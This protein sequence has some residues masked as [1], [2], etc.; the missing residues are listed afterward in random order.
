MRKK[1]TQQTAQILE[2]LWLVSKFSDDY[3]ERRVLARM[4]WHTEISSASYLDF[5]LMAAGFGSELQ[6]LD[7]DDYFKNGNVWFH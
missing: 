4:L 7:D 3:G 1:N 6:A 2:Q 5:V